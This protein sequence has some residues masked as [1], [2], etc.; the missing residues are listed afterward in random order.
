M[1]QCAVLVIPR[2]ALGVLF[3]TSGFYKTQAALAQPIMGF[4]GGYGMTHAYGW[5]RPFIQN[6]NV[7]HPGLFGGLVT[8]G[9]IYVGISL[10]LG[11]TT[12]LAAGVGL[13]MLLNFLST[14]GAMPWNPSVVDIP[15]IVICVTLILG[16]AGRTFGLDKYLYERFPKVPI[17]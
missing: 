8:V 2:I 10:I 5:Y 7:P 15:D 14:K 3:L 17:W 6:V 13:F 12:R 4:V 9:E 11:L 16:A 1:K